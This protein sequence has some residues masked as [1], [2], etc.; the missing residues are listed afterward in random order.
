MLGALFHLPGWR[1]ALDIV[2]LLG[3]GLVAFL[4]C[5][6]RVNKYLVFR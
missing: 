5:R 2:L 4:Y 3:W 6:N 1:I